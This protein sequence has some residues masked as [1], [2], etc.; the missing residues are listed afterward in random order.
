MLWFLKTER[1]GEIFN[2]V[3]FF[4]N[5]SRALLV[6]CS[7]QVN[8]PLIANNNKKPEKEGRQILLVD[9]EKK[10]VI[11]LC[12]DHSQVRREADP[13]C[14]NLLCP[15]PQSSGHPEELARLLHP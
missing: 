2:L 5:K 4:A 7:T 15:P 9:E 11:T 6:L 3:L 13:D 10:D 14:R 8:Y 1:T 12:P